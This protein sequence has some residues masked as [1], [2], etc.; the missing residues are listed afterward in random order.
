MFDRI[1]RIATTAALRAL[2]GNSVPVAY[3]ESSDGLV[4]KDTDSNVHYLPKSRDT[5]ALAADFTASSADTG[6]TLT[7]LTGFTWAVEAVA[8]NLFR[9]VNP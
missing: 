2:T 1:R 7:S 9:M 5:K 4:F 8:P 3:D 6:T